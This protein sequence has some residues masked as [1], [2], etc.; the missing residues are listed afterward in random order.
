VR[1]DQHFHIDFEEAGKSILNI[2]A[3]RAFDVTW[4]E[5]LEVNLDGD[6]L[7]DRAA[8]GR[9]KTEAV[10]GVVLG[11]KRDTPFIFRFPR[12]NSQRGICAERREARLTVEAR[13]AADDADAPA[14]ARQPKTPGGQV[15][16]TVRL[17][18]GDCDAFHFYFDGKTV[19]WWRR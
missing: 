2:L 16:Q 14:A 4:G 11:S 13:P 9:T 5:V 6:D 7:A 17:D 10:V 15:L 1:H 18:A 12:D 19:T 8:L 3:R